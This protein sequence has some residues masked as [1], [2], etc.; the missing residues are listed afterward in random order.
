MNSTPDN[1]PSESLD[2]PELKRLIAALSDGQLQPAEHDRLESLLRKHRE[3]RAIYMAYMQIDSGLDWKVRGRQSVRSLADLPLDGAVATAADRTREPAGPAGWLRSRRVYIGSTLAASLGLVLASIA[4]IVSQEAAN[5]VADADATDRNP[6]MFAAVDAGASV[7]KVVELSDECRWFVENRRHGDDFVVVGDKV[8]LTRGQLRMEF[9]CGATVTMKSPA[10]L[11][12]VSPTR[13]RAVLGTLTAHVEKGAEG[14]TV[15]TPRTTVVDLGTDFGIDVSDHGSTDVVVFTGAVDVHSDGVEGLGSRQ[16]LQAGEGVRV[17]GE[18][19][20]SRIVAIDDSQFS[21]TAGGEPQHRT[22]VIA[23]VSDNISRGESWYYYEVV[24]GG[25]REDARSFVD[26]PH[27]WNGV[28]GKGMPSYLLGAD[29]VKTFNDDKVNQKVEIRVTLERPAILYVL[30]DKRSPPPNWLR[31]NFFN[32]YDE[33]GLDGG[34]YKRFGIGAEKTVDIGPGNSVDD[35]FSIWR[36]DVPKAGTVKLGAMQSGGQY[37]NMYGIAAVP[38]EIHN[39]RDDFAGSRRQVTNE[40]TALQLDEGGKLA[41]DG[42]IER[43]GDFDLFSFD[44]RGGAAE[45]ACETSGLTTLDPTLRV[46]DANGKLVG[47]ARAK[48]ANRERTAVTMNLPEGEYFAEIAGGNDI[49]EVGTYQVQVAKSSAEV[50]ESPPGPAELKLRAALTDAGVVLSWNGPPDA[51]SYTV[52]KSCDA[53]IFEPMIS[54]TETSAVDE[55]LKSGATRIYR[56]RADTSAGQLE[57]EPLLVR[58]K[59]APVERLGALGLSSKSVVLEWSTSAD[60]EGYRIERSADGERFDTIGTAPQHAN[61]YRDLDVQPG[62]RYF[63]RVV[64]L[65]S[66]DGDAT[67]MPVQAWSGVADVAATATANNRV[68]ISW[69]SDYPQARYYVQ[70][71]NKGSDQFVTVGAVDG[72]MQSHV[73]QTAIPGSTLKYRILAV[74]DVSKLEH[75]KEDAINTIRLPDGAED[76]DYF[77]LQIVGKLR[78]DETRHYTFFLN[79]DD[80]SKLFIDGSLVVDNDGRHAPLKVAGTTK[81]AAGYHDLE[82]QYFQIDGRRA[83]DLGWNGPGP[84]QVAHFRSPDPYLSDL[85][86]RYYEGNWAQS[87]FEKVAAVSSIVTVSTP[88]TSDANGE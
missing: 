76:D 66:S 3:A 20:A 45:V 29:Y 6:G 38:L 36:L 2:V 26:R 37:H 32:T 74:E 48:P 65:N 69:A 58:G 13:T 82:V 14:F 10:A 57:G 52:E 44:W 87:P 60:S 84:P 35:T 53:V 4:W 50:P 22:P 24:H 11:E 88:L 71:A 68:E 43:P 86:Y 41:I 67:S 1:S 75:S 21:I 70:R 25:L 47:Y 28:K 85:K 73:D 63:Y 54:T 64:T 51:K 9:E 34:G 42:A 80:G 16:R 17:S 18:G 49:G 81:L 61:G 7:A 72:N 12:V 55:K 62:Q 39:G 23:A 78:I 77:G 83:L 59:S 15:E 56:L 19:T 5:S 40:I 46:Y 79:S 8:R 33:V 31:E 27:E 30:L